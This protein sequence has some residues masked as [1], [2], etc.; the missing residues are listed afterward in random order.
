[1]YGKYKVF[2]IKKILEYMYVCVINIK[3]NKLNEF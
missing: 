1:M 2:L 3:L